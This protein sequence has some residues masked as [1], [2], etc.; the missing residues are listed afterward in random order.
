MKIILL[1]LTSLLL[2][3][4]STKVTNLIDGV[5]SKKGKHSIEV[6][7]LKNGSFKYWSK[8]IPIFSD[9]YVSE[10]Y[11]GKYTFNKNFLTLDDQHFFI[12]RLL[13]IKTPRKI[14]LVDQHAHK[15]WKEKKN[16]DGFAVLFKTP[17]KTVI[18]PYDE[19]YKTLK[20]N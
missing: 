3:C 2:S 13:F 15:Q 1:T 17:L 12:K 9:Y 6:I 7:E 5:Y 11:T 8:N 16:V 4:S 10:M 20:P 19:V 18:E 14:M